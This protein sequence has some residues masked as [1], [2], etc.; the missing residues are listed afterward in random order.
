MLVHAR[1]RVLSIPFVSSNTFGVYGGFVLAQQA[2]AV[3]RRS[4]EIL[5]LA[6]SPLVR[7][8]REL[9]IN[10]LSFAAQ[11]NAHT[12]NIRGTFAVIKALTKH[13]IRAPPA[14]RLLDGTIIN[15]EV[16]RQ[17]R[18]HEHFCDVFNGKSFANV[19][20]LESVTRLSLDVSSVCVDW[21]PE[22]IVKVFAKMNP[23]KGL[24]LDALP[25]NVWSAGGLPLMRNVSKLGDIIK[26][27]CIWP[28]ALQGSRMVDLWKGKG[29]RTICDL[30]RGLGVLGHLTKSFLLPHI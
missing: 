15:D 8:D 28:V 1:R 22:N 29:D 13:S 19:T 16:R 6:V 21:S 7:E 11:R 12:G 25:S 2:N 3:V 23:R 9:Y 5:H 18:W 4:A 10:S 24:G 20:H 27:S 26:S 30:S 17:Q 14:V